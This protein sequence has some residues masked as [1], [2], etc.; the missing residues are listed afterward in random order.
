MTAINA[1]LM[2]RVNIVVATATAKNRG[3]E[4]HTLTVTLNGQHGG[5]DVLLQGDMPNHNTIY[6]RV[7][8][9]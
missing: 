2:Q 6:T 5:A 1:D 3:V 7:V 9:H 8:V 4:W